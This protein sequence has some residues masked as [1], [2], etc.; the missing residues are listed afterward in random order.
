VPFDER[1]AAAVRARGGSRLAGW[2]AGV[3]GDE[4]ARLRARVVVVGG[5]AGSPVAGADVVLA[6]AGPRAGATLTTPEVAAGVDAGRELAAAAARDGINVIAGV[7][8]AGAG[9]LAAW[10][11]GDAPDPE[12][13]GPLGALRRLGGG[14]L[15]VLTGLALG[16]GERGLGYVCQGAAAAAAAAVALEVEPD[17]R[18]RVLGL[19]GGDDVLAALSVVR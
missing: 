5:A 14:E 6:A 11:T 8:D 16:A 17:L 3:S 9:A 4:C 2:L 1:A 7:S 19:A 15:T 13:R 10:L 12:I 18:A